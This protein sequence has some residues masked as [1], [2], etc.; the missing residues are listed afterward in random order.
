LEGLPR[1]AESLFNAEK[2]RELFKQIRVDAGWQGHASVHRPEFNGL[3]VAGGIDV[4]WEFVP[5]ENRAKRTDLGFLAALQPGAILGFNGLAEI[6][7]S[8]MLDK[9]IDGGFADSKD[10]VKGVTFE[11][12]KRS[13]VLG[14]VLSELFEIRRDLRRELEIDV[15]RM[16]IRLAGFEKSGDT[17]TPASVLRR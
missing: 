9:Q 4:R 7:V 8:L 11:L 13:T 3:M 16:R 1:A 15:V 12:V 2:L 10:V 5:P 17:H 14:G 6:A